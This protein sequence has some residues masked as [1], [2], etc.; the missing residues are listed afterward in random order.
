MVNILMIPWQER[1]EKGVMD[2]RTDRRADRQVYVRANMPT[3]LVLRK[4]SHSWVCGVQPTFL[5]GEIQV[6]IWQSVHPRCVRFNWGKQPLVVHLFVPWK[7]WLC[8]LQPL[9]VYLL[10]RPKWCLVGCNPYLSIYVSVF[11]WCSSAIY[12]GWINM[13]L[14]L[15]ANYASKYSHL[16][17][18]LTACL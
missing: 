13:Q 17:I 1:G 3:A 12:G 11:M 14:I 15:N 9:V 2:R 5:W 8:G 16:M 4:F 18:L 10:V 7:M 6:S